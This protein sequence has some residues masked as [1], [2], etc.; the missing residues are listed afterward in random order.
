MHWLS[1]I[2]R[3]PIRVTAY[4]AWLCYTQVLQRMD[5]LEPSEELGWSM[6]LCIDPEMTFVIP[7]VGARLANE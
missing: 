7:V 5:I 3:A 1:G 2:R 4:V 6:F